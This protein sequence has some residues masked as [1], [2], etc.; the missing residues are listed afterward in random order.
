MSR[1]RVF[2]WLQAALCAAVAALL[3]AGAV[4]IYREGMAL[5]AAGDPS[6]WIYTRQRVAERLGRVLP[7]CG[8]AVGMAAAGILLGIRDG[9]ARPGGRLSAAGRA[10][11]AR[12]EP[13][14][15]QGRGF[16]ALRAAL[17]ALAAALVIHGVCN[18]SMRDVFVKTVNICTECVGLG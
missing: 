2:L 17:L 11:L 5:R 14:P 16:K 6:A 7:L 12:W 8:V 13:A 10:D 4:G 18:G 3:A 15:V 9:E 1:K